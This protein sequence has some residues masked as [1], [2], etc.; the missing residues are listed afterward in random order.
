MTKEEWIEENLNCLHQIELMDMVGVCMKF[1][2]LSEEFYELF[3]EE[4]LDE[5]K[6]KYNQ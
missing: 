6:E 2:Q 3:G 5:L 1:A 4:L